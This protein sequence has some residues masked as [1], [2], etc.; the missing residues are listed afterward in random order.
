LIE[1]PDEFEPKDALTQLGK[2]LAKKA[3]E[4]N[5]TYADITSDFQKAGGKKL[6]EMSKI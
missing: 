1:Q 2:E 5:I 4:L 6:F 3:K